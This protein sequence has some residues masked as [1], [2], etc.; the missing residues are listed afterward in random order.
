MRYRDACDGKEIFENVT[1]CRQTCETSFSDM[2]DIPADALT[3]VK[4]NL[5]S[6][7][8]CENIQS[9]QSEI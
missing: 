6:K 7:Y 5:D 4:N 8:C 3:C 1:L 9:I 2:D